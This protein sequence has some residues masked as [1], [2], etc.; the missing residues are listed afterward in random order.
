MKNEVYES[1][2]TNNGAEET[3]EE[4]Q[5]TGPKHIKVRIIIHVF[6][7]KH[8]LFGFAQF[9]KTDYKSNDCVDNKNCLHRIHIFTSLHCYG[10]IQKE[11]QNAHE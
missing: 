4:P 2:Y 10:S 9:N 11:K 3:Q 5:Y 1:T 6:G 7:S 8:P